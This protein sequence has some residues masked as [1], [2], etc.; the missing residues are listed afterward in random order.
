MDDQM[1]IDMLESLEREIDVFVRR[2][3]E[4]KFSEDTID[5]YVQGL[6]TSALAF[7]FLLQD[8]RWEIALRDKQEIRESQ[9]ISETQDL[10]DMLDKIKDEGEI[11]HPSHRGDD[12]ISYNPVDQGIIRIDFHKED[13]RLVVVYNDEIVSESDG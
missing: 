8:I 6:A 11:V 2:V 10:F 1:T 13:E 3:R 4:R 12:V 5:H 7:R 9:P